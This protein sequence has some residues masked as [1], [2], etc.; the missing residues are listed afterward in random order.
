LAHWDSVWGRPETLLFDLHHQLL[1]GE[2]GELISGWLGI[3]AVLFC[4]TGLIL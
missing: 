1:M 4:M 3:A 2:T